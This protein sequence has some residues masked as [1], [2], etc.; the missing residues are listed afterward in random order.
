MM[1]LRNIF[2]PELNNHFLNF[3]REHGEPDSWLNQ[4]QVRFAETKLKPTRIHISLQIDF[5]KIVRDHFT[6]LWMGTGSMGI[7][8]HRWY[9]MITINLG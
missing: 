1:S 8:F 3:N 9:T 2:H 7:S 5:K 4:R 6:L